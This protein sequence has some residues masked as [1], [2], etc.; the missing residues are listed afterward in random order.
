MRSIME[1]LQSSGIEGRG[2]GHGLPEKKPTAAEQK[3]TEEVYKTHP[4]G[5]E[6]P[7]APHILSQKKLSTEE[8]LPQKIAHL[9]NS[10]Q[11]AVARRDKKM[12]VNLGLQAKNE[13][14][15]RFFEQGISKVVTKDTQ[16]F[17][18]ECHQAF[19]FADYRNHIVGQIRLLPKDLPI[20]Q[21]N[22]IEDL[23][24][25]V[26][27]AIKDGVSPQLLVGKVLNSLESLKVPLHPNTYAFLDRLR[28][29]YQQQ[30]EVASEGVSV[31]PITV[32]YA[33]LMEN[34]CR[35][36]LEDGRFDKLEEL[37][38]QIDAFGLSNL[39][40]LADQVE[41]LEKSPTLSAAQSDNCR[42]IANYLN[43]YEKYESV[44]DMTLP[45]YV[46]HRAERE[47]AYL[48]SAR[49]LH[50]SILDN[51]KAMLDKC[52]DHITKN[53]LSI[54]KIFIFLSDAQVNPGIK[55]GAKECLVRI[56][57]AVASGR[58]VDIKN[59]LNSFFTWAVSRVS[60]STVLQEAMNA[61]S[62]KQKLYVAIEQ[63][64]QRGLPFLI[65]LREAID[66]LPEPKNMRLAEQIFSEVK[67][68]TEKSLHNDL[69]EA[70]LNHDA[71]R[72]HRAID[73]VKSNG[74]N[75]HVHLQGAISHLKARGTSLSSIG[76]AER[77]LSR[78]EALLNVPLEVHGLDLYELMR[79]SYIGE[80]TITDAGQRTDVIRLKRTDPG[81]QLARS[82][83]IDF[84]T[85]NFTIISGEHG[86]VKAKGGF[87]K[88]RSAVE[89]SL[90]QIGSNY[91]T[92]ATHI[93]RKTPHKGTQFSPEEIAFEKEFGDVRT[94]AAYDSHG[95]QK[96]TFTQSYYKSDWYKLLMGGVGFVSD[97]QMIS[98]LLQISDKIALM[99]SSDKRV[100]HRDLKLQNLLFGLNGE[101]NGS[102]VADFGLSYRYRAGMR[103]P[104]HP[105]FPLPCYGTILFTSPELIAGTLPSHDEKY[106]YAQDMF[107]LGALLYQVVTKKKI[108]WKKDVQIWAEKAKLIKDPSDP[109]Q[110]K[111]ACNPMIIESVNAARQDLLKT[112][113]PM[114]NIIS[115]LLNPDPD[116]RM[117]IEQFQASLKMV[118]PRN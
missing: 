12:L 79:I 82:L 111:Q 91:Q 63:A 17:V 55:S 117:T 2:A 94:V 29:Y 113:H 1:E 37:L 89:V 25:C 28:G 45:K 92:R 6:Q 88:I 49:M 57:D 109:L 27:G 108:P 40:V 85:K 68:G 10:I 83:L 18:R 98:N 41:L 114:A 60:L 7:T 51:D 71:M 78:F 15:A 5:T 76:F 3:K 56:S 77:V 115:E 43:D 42:M 52:I 69:V 4:P 62:A 105:R 24:N 30:S 86:S 35:K 23:N 107:A 50:S 14:L 100:I 31:S 47:K 97:T 13:G 61:D 84:S 44:R 73:L 22:I 93:V 39:A 104:A 95:R 87:G 38:V 53:A 16:K 99:H 101:D 11:D 19:L 21:S 65:M 46:K 34:Q 118:K 72:L 81:I 96:L 33:L 102:R 106:H 75:C 64:R 112:G 103:I 66:E 116:K 48:E 20:D 67:S 9:Q 8:N 58:P 26:M 110:V 36:L 90:A 80:K 59:F 70:F 74:L 32:T 54:E